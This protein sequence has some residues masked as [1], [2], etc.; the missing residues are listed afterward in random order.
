MY[1]IE[2]N[3]TNSFI[4]KCNVH[5]FGFAILGSLK[6]P[7]GAQRAHLFNTQTAPKVIE[8]QFKINMLQIRRLDF[9]YLVE[10]FIFMMR[11]LIFI[12]VF[13]LVLIGR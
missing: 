4:L 12:V 7:F 11:L 6:F 8:C 9:K 2:Q 5:R 13:G 3:K 10:I 1:A